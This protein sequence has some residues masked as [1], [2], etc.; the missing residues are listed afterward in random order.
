MREEFAI[1]LSRWFG[2]SDVAAEIVETAHVVGVFDASFVV[3]AFTHVHTSKGTH[4][5][6]LILRAFGDGVFSTIVA[7]VIALTVSP[8]VLI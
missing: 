7:S 4:D 8:H 6:V 2:A 3:H 5:A 1:R